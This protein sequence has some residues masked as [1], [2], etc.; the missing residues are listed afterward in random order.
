MMK[1]VCEHNSSYG[2][3]SLETRMGCG[4]GACM[5]CAVEMKSGMKRICKEGPVFKKEEILWE[6]LR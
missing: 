3:T 6:N 4:F 1:S 2:L 5:G